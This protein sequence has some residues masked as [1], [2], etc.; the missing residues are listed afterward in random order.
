MYACVQDIK[1]YSNSLVPG[2]HGEAAW[3]LCNLEF[4]S[5]NFW[6]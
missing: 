1:F 6:I 4:G 2:Y 3:T 5:S